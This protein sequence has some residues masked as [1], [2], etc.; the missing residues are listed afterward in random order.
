MTLFSVQTYCVN[1]EIYIFEII[2]N[3]DIEMETCFFALLIGMN[4]TISTLVFEG[5][6][7]N[8][9]FNSIIKS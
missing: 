8:L 5:Q 1:L 6:L 9:H 2:K 4:F 7:L 3:L